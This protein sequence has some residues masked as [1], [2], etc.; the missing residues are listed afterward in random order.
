MRISTKD[1]SYHDDEKGDDQHFDAEFS[2]KREILSDKREES[3]RFE[4]INNTQCTK[5]SLQTD[6]D[7]SILML[8]MKQ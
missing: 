3:A 8:T 7:L 5:F 6:A 1:T 4:R 2:Q